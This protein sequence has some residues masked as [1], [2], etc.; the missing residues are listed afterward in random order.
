MD[1]KFCRGI[2]SSVCK[3]QVCAFLLSIPRFNKLVIIHR[4]LVLRITD[5]QPAN[6]RMHAVPYNHGKLN[7]QAFALNDLE[8]LA[9]H[10]S[11]GKK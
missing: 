1:I 11:K 6:L 3:F 9:K 10:L 2:V 8:V 4:L 7:G 5:T